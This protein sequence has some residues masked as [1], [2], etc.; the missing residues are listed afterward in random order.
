M[1]G[2]LESQPNPPSEA[3]SEDLAGPMVSMGPV[4]EWVRDPPATTRAQIR[5]AV[6]DLRKGMAWAE[7][8]RPGF[9]LH[10][11]ICR[12]AGVHPKSPG[13]P[14][15]IAERLGLRRQAYDRLLRKG[16]TLAV[17]S[18]ALR[19]GLAVVVLPPATDSGEPRWVIGDGRIEVSP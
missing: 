2:E 16:E 11:A 14:I 19:V 18:A 10:C 12:A 4:A 1:T 9:V 5:A 7:G 13:V 17:V 3:V 8:T 6:V 15:A